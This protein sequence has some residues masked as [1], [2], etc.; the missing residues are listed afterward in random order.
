MAGAAPLFFSKRALK[1]LRERKTKPM[2]YNWVRAPLAHQ[3]P[4][5]CG[6]HHD[7]LGKHTGGLAIVAACKGFFSCAAQSS[8]M[9]FRRWQLSCAVCVLS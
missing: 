9:A 1:K 3:H 6:H 4:C 8:D 5:S 2:S 7:V